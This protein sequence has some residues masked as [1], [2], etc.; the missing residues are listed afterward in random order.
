MI[1][2]VRAGDSSRFPVR[3]SLFVHCSAGLSPSAV[4][5]V[6]LFRFEGAVK[7]YFIDALRRSPEGRIVMFLRPWR[8]DNTAS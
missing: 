4:A 6:R 3:H 7:P 1:W 5:G 8:S 2:L